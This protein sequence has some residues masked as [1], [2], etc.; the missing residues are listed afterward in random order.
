MKIF[1]LIIW[2]IVGVATAI[3]HFT[4]RADQFYYEIMFWLTYIA[5]MSFILF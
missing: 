1:S 3:D 4:H 2:G 5:L